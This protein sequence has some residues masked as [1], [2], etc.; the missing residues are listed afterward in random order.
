M[1]TRIIIQVKTAEC[2]FLMISLSYKKLRKWSN[3]A[4][5][6]LLFLRII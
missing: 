1:V 3:D 5:F 4:C 2:D 6:S